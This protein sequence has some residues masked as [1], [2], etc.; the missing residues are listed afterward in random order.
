MSGYDPTL[1]CCISYLCAMSAEEQLLK[2]C[3]TAIEAQLGWGPASGW[4]NQDFTDL[5]ERIL[6][7]TEVQLSPTTLKRVWGRVAYRSSPSPTTLDALAV[8]LDYPNYRAFRQAAETAAPPPHPKLRRKARNPLRLYAYYLAPLGVLAWLIYYFAPA[9]S[10]APATAAPETPTETLNPNDY[11]FSFRPVTTGIPNS[12]I[13]NYN[14]SAAPYDSVFLQQSWD[15]RRRAQIPRAGDTYTSI[16]YYPGFY[17]AKLLV[18]NQIVQHRDVFIRSDDWVAAV[19]QDPTPIYLPLDQVRQNGQLAITTKQLTNLD[20]PLEPPPTTM[21]T[22]AG[23]LTGL[24]TNDF[25]FRTRLRHGY[26][27]GSAACQHTQ[28]TLLLKGSAIIIPLS[29]PGCVA[30]LDLFANGQSVS[31]RDHD[32]SA[33]GAIGDTFLELAV[34][35]KDNLLTFAVNGKDI[36]TLKTTDPVREI[37]G[38]RYA[39]AGTGAVEDVVF[40]DSGGVVWEEGF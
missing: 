11:H 34:T 25:S 23:Q 36:Y 21:L 35:G 8:F 15:G 20:L 38:I 31:G 13:F 40:R 4:S 16:Y 3:L 17:N 12:V 22:T 24:F 33:F 10:I 19:A 30:E 39:F 29:Q 14:A 37:I 6:A 5:S 32:L 28:V 9:P 27:A 18:G 7:K 2:Q 1:I 26:T